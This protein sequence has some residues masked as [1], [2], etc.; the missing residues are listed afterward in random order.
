M[1]S[2][3]CLGRSRCRCSGLRRR[4]WRCRRLGRL[5]LC[6]RCLRNLILFLGGLLRGKIPEMF[7]HELGVAQVDGARVRLL[8]FDADFREVIDQDL[9]LD[10]ELPCQLVNSNLIR[11]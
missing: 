10:F 7:A 5:R 6:G 1:N 4:G 2:W 3:R 11:I 9:G 8:F